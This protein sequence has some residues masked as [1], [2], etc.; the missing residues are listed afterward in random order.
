MK[1]VALL[2]HS[3]L[4]LLPSL[5]RYLNRLEQS[6]RLVERLLVLGLRHAI[7]HDA[8]A[9]LDVRGVVLDHQRAQRDAG[10]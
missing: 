1:F 4:G 6:P 3:D 10:L 8:R 9:G 2:L 7:R 5:L